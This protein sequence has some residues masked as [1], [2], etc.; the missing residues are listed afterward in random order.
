M[1]DCSCEK[2]CVPR[3]LRWF[4]SGGNSILSNLSINYPGSAFIGKSSERIYW[5]SEKEWKVI[6]SCTKSL[7]WSKD[8]KDWSGMGE[9]GNQVLEGKVKDEIAELIICGTILIMCTWNIFS[10]SNCGLTNGSNYL[11]READLYSYQKGTYT[12]KRLDNQQREISKN[13]K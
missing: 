7:R 8:E 5:L 2:C 13:L 4:Y 12:K 3:Y 9:E 11:I 1:S 6:D 10:F